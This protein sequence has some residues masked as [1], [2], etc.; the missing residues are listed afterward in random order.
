MSGSIYVIGR[1][2]SDGR[3]VATLGDTD[4]DAPPSPTE[5]DRDFDTWQEALAWADDQ[6]TDVDAIVD[7]G[8]LGEDELAAADRMNGLAD[9]A[10]KFMVLTQAT[11]ALDDFAMIFPDLADE[12]TRL[13]E[14]LAE[15]STK[16][17]ELLKAKSREYVNELAD[18][19]D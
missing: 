17:A 9:Q 19:A 2:E 6:D 5:G 12:L 15:A 1:R 16:I 13:S 18:D 7:R 10:G 11:V 3:I 8:L 14:D 4:A